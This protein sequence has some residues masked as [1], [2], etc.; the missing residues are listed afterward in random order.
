MTDYRTENKLLHSV[1]IVVA[2]TAISV[3][4]CFVLQSMS[5]AF[6]G[7]VLPSDSVR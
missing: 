4:I 1:I 6:R 5:Y 3:C 2:K 7:Q